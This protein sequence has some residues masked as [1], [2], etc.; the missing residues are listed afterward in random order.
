MTD[1]QPNKDNILDHPKRLL[2]G[3]AAIGIGGFLVYKLVRKLITGMQKRSTEKQANDS[4]EV[5]QAMMLRSAMNPSGITWMMSF[6]T[7]NTAAVFDMARQIKSLDDVIVAYRKLYDDDLLHDLQ[8]ELS[9][10]DYQKFLTM[11]SSNPEKKGGSA[12][13]KFAAKQ[14]MVVAKAEVF[15]RTSPDASYHGAIYEVLEKINIIR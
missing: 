3:G 13:V 15:L 4:P 11:V 5:R 12:P 14:Q 9:A 2:V 8:N 6:D 1:N 10:S 7:T